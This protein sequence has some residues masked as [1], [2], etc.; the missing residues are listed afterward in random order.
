MPHTINYN[1]ET[2]V[3]EVKIH[4]DFRLSEGK[5]II[6]YLVQVIKEQNCFFVNDMREAKMKLSTVDI[7]ELP[8]LIT[9]IFSSSEVNS[10]KLKRA[11]VVTK[12]LEDYKFFETVTANRRQQV[13][14]FFDIDEAKKWL[15]EK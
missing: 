13:M 12:D 1:L 8:K 10:Y 9:S 15:L 14:L 6:T 4:G 2:H 11:L 5:E 7:Y 3:I